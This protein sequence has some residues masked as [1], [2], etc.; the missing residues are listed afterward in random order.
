MQA[1]VVSFEPRMRGDGGV[2]S[3]KKDCLMPLEK[4]ENRSQ[5]LQTERK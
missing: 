4:P 5:I 3:S 2:S 1:M